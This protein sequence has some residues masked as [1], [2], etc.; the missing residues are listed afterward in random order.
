MS[1]HHLSEVEK[2]ADWVGIIDQGKLLLEAQLDD[3][4]ANYRRVRAI[5]ERLPERGP[6]IVTVSATEGV[7]DYVVSADA[8][9]FASSLRGQGA[10]ILDVSPMNL[11]EIFLV[12]V[13]K[14]SHVPVEVLA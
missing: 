5:G 8:D 14:E 6:E 2:I 3:I 1:S 4:R 11:S 9:G 7:F 12:L 13:G 10:T